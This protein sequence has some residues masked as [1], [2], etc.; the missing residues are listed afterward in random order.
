MHPTYT[1]QLIKEKTLREIPGDWTTKDYLQI[2]ELTEYGD[3][4]GLSDAEAAEM[5]KMSLADLPKD[6]AAS[7]LLDYVFPGD[8]LT[9]G[10]RQNAAHEMDT[11]SLWEEYPEPDKHRQFFRAATLLYSAYNGGF[12]K[13]EAQQLELRITPAKPAGRALLEDPEPAFLLRLLAAG[14]DGHALLHRLFETELTGTSFPN[15]PYIIWEKSVVE[16]GDDF[17]VT[18]ISSTYWLDA[19]HPIPVYETQAWE[20]EVPEED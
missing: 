16:E 1:V 12:P 15:A 2:L 17:L 18:I 4:S 7:L 6:E 11:E 3:T 20:D 9:K 13:P 19:Y 10:Q 5:A 8:T 14:M